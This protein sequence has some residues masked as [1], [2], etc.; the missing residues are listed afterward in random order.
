MELLATDLNAGPLPNAE[1]ENA[2]VIDTKFQQIDGFVTVFWN[3][4]CQE[5]YL[6]LPCLLCSLYKLLIVINFKNGHSRC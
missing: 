6:L 5:A 1:C 4:K 3:H 2:T